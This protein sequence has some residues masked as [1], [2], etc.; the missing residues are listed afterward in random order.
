MLEIQHNRHLINISNRM[1][2]RIS[3]STMRFLVIHTPSPYYR[4][5][6]PR[7]VD[8][9]DKVNVNIRIQANHMK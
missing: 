5:W 8:E 6:T 9:F 7:Q 2:E 3:Q 4:L 1:V